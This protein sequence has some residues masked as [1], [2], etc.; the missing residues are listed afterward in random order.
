MDALG[1]SGR[2]GVA[3][4]SWRFWESTAI[5]RTVLLLYMRCRVGSER[6]PITIG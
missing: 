3:V 1:A 6:V 5:G 2:N 4:R